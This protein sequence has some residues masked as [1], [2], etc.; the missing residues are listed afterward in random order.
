[1]SFYRCKREKKIQQPF[2]QYSRMSIFSFF[3]FPPVIQSYLLSPR[4]VVCVYLRIVYPGIIV[5]NFKKISE[6][7]WDIIH[8]HVFSSLMIGVW[9]FP[10][11]F[12]SSLV[13]CLSFSPRYE[14]IG[15]LLTLSNKK[16]KKKLFSSINLFL[17][18]K[19][20]IVNNLKMKKNK[21]KF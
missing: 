2:F 17:S 5:K 7:V 21:G 4:G 10:K 6:S 11:P 13:K 19:I 18:H 1:M 15:R 3:E 8:Q 12:I 9:I 16:R 14:V 20:V